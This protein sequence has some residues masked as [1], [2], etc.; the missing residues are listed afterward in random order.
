MDYSSVRMPESYNDPIL[1]IQLKRQEGILESLGRHALGTEQDPTFL[2]VTLDALGASSLA[3]VNAV[4]YYRRGL[5]PF[6]GAGQGL[7]LA[8]QPAQRYFG[9][10]TTPVKAKN[11]YWSQYLETFPGMNPMEGGNFNLGKGLLTSTLGLGMDIGSDPLTWLSGGSSGLIK[12]GAVALARV[13]PELS[14]MT[15]EGRAIAQAE[16]MKAGIKLQPGAL[17][18]AML[19]EGPLNFRPATI[20]GKPEMP[21]VN[22]EQWNKTG[23]PE[24]GKMLFPY[25]GV[26]TSLDPI[27]EEFRQEYFKTDGKRPN[28]GLDVP[29]QYYSDPAQWRWLRKALFK[30]APVN[31]P[32]LRDTSAYVKAASLDEALGSMPSAFPKSHADILAPPTSSPTK[33][34][35][36][37]PFRVALEELGELKSFPN[38]FKGNVETTT[39]MDY[40]RPRLLERRYYQPLK[41]LG[42]SRFSVANP[43]DMI[44]AFTTAVSTHYGMPPLVKQWFRD[45][46]T[47]EVQIKQEAAEITEG[48][49]KRLGR[50]TDELERLPHYIEAAKNQKLI[51][52]GVLPPT[53]L[54]TVDM[55]TDPARKK[56]VMDTLE[57]YNAIFAKEGTLPRQLMDSGI[58]NEFLDDYVTHIY[59]IDPNSSQAWRKSMLEMSGSD[60]K[61]PFDRFTEF[62]R[63]IETL[64][65]ALMMKM[66]MEANL[67]VI[68]GLRYASAR[69]AIEKKGF[70]ERMLSEGRGDIKTPMGP[71]RGMQPLIARPASPQEAEQLK[72]LGY[73]EMKDFPMMRGYMVSDPV[74]LSSHWMFDSFKS[75]K[76]TDALSAASAFFKPLMTFVNPKYHAR[77]FMGN[78]WQMHLAG[79]DSPMSMLEALRVQYPEGRLAGILD[80]MGVKAHPVAMPEGSVGVFDKMLAEE[81]GLLRRGQF[82]ADM[83]DILYTHLAR[84]GAVGLV[85]KGW[86]FPFKVGA[87]VGNF[88]EDNARIALYI[89]GMK[90]GLSQDEAI[91][92]VAKF[93][94]N[95]DELTPIEQNLRRNWFWFYTWYRKNMPLQLEMFFRTPGKY[96]AIPRVSEGIRR[97]ATAFD[98]ETLSRD[99]QNQIQPEWMAKGTA[100]PLGHDKKGR[101][102]LFLPGLPYEDLNSLMPGEFTKNVIS[103]LSP[104]VKAPVELFTGLDLY[105]AKPFVNQDLEKEREFQGVKVPNSYWEVVDRLGPAGNLLKEKLNMRHYL[106]PTTGEG[107]TEVDP[108]MM[109]LFR[110]FFRPGREAMQA[111]DY[112]ALQQ[113]PGSFWQNI[114]GS[115]Y[116]L[117]TEQALKTAGYRRKKTQ[118]E[119]LRRRQQ[120]VLPSQRRYNR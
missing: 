116:P 5:N 22:Y 9:Q 34:P 11:Q 114:F 113:D 26:K 62:T 103:N 74:F 50:Y 84:K 70:M 79:F 90:K 6:T 102:R 89:D 76:F 19:R 100:L 29:V 94:F 93:L 66:P 99:E 1:D 72:A 111:L 104:M 120:D 20:Y 45:W 44:G 18:A 87:E 92:R 106:N 52:D 4:D 73:T 119:A 7:Q 69:K 15:K 112:G 27:P 67:A 13:R 2:R 75:N 49:V 88:I 40:W 63:K 32:G 105:R 54:K 117:D 108:R 68:A 51:D 110:T 35:S 64:E 3:T 39:T 82:S 8:F 10:T 55:I 57:Y 80:S 21:L 46:K 77:N 24:V 48:I 107:V 41:P 101:Q 23:I 71:E 86:N 14:I 96:S 25:K 118:E 38:K 47:K 109:Y 56:A 60:A 98:P 115:M 16:M 17:D 95:Y 12:R 97:Y 43:L 91:D 81:L 30:E 42:I 61:M 53:A 58:S 31:V 28:R 85:E 33:L 37:D 59:R 36:N 78:L 65:Q 83:E